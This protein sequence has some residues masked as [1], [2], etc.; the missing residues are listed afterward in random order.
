MDG[1]DLE[2]KVMEALSSWLDRIG[3]I[4]KLTGYNVKEDMID[5]FVHTISLARVNNTFGPDF[6]TEGIRKIYEGCL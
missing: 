4:T 2:E 5:Q 3:L 1:A 6:S